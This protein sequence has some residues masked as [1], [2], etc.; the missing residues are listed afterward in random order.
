MPLADMKAVM[1]GDLLV[2]ARNLLHAE[3]VLPHGLTYVG[4]GR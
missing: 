4:V 2:D 3:D 1:R